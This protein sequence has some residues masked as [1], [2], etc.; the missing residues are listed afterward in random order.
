MIQNTSSRLSY[1]H[2]FSEIKVSLEGHLLWVTLNRPEFSNAFSITMMDELLPVLKKAN[3]DDQVRVIIIQGAGK[4]FCAGGDI[5]DMENKAG[6]FAGEPNELRENYMQGIQ[7]IPLTMNSLQK[8]VIALVQGAAVGAGCDFACMCDIR[9]GTSK[10]KF[11][12]TFSKL[13]LVP[14]DGGTFFLSRVVGFAKACEMFFTGDVIEAEEAQRIGLL[15]FIVN[16]VEAVEKVKAF[17]TKIAMN[18]PIAV[19]MTKRALIHAQENSLQAHLDL[20]AAFQGISQRTTDHHLGLEA[21]K[22]KTTAQFQGH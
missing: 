18:A 16:E 9:I 15:N 7:Q 8:P 17:A 20:L 12:E 3:F 10:A 13:S 6:M 4:A 22:N 11:A 2:S 1:E 14:G 21:L 19:K 5:K